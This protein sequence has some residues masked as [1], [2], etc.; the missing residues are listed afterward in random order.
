[1]DWNKI[2]SFIANYEHEYMSVTVRNQELHKNCI[3]ADVNSNSQDIL[4]KLT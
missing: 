4:H 1:M 2:K 3:H